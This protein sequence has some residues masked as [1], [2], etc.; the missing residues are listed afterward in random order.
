VVLKLLITQDP[1]LLQP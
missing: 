1:F